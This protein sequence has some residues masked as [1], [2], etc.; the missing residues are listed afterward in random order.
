LRGGDVLE[1]E[2]G[3]EGGFALVGDDL[4][5]S[6]GVVDGDGPEELA[7]YGLGHGQLVGFAAIEGG[8]GIVARVV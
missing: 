4:A 5:S 6:V 2:E 1:F 3:A 8:A 7:G